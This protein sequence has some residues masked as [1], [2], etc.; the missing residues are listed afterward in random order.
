MENSEKA[1]HI[2]DLVRMKLDQGIDVYIRARADLA[3]SQTGSEL[4]EKANPASIGFSSN[5][6]NVDLRQRAVDEALKEKLARQEL[7][8]Y[9]IEIFLNKID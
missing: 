7:L 9:A 8:D 3:S 1:K 6:Y 5:P 2:V 4:W